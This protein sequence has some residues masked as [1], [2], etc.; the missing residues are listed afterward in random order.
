MLFLEADSGA[1][2]GLSDG[3]AGLY[4][5]LGELMMVIMGIGALVVLAMIILHVVNGDQD[6]LKKLFWWLI[7]LA[8]GCAMM[9]FLT[10]Y[11]G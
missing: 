9:A 5:S 4:G 11:F 8:F 2:T 10:S 7:G 3:L 6:G 1:W